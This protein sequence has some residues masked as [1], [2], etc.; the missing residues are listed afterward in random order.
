VPP[1]KSLNGLPCNA[2]DQRGCGLGIATGK[3]DVFDSDPGMVTGGGV[4]IFKDGELVGGIGVAG[5]HPVLAEFAAFAVSVPDASFGPRPAEPRVSLRDGVQLP[6]VEQATRPPGSGPGTLAGGVFVIAPS[7]SPRMARGVPDGWL[8]GPVSS[9]DLS[10]S[11]VI[12]IVRQA[13][14]QA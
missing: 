6:F 3:P 1:S 7:D 12:L 14:A 9:S 8:I 4:P 2:T 11:D 13:V 5:F 10:Q